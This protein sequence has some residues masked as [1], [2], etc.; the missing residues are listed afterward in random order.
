ML[1]K[2]IAC[3]CSF[4]LLFSMTAASYAEPDDGVGQTIQIYTRF[5]T[6]VGRPSWLLVIRDVDHNQNIPYLFDIERG[7][8][9]WLAFTRGRNYLITIS[10][11]QFAP[12]KGMPYY[13]T[14]KINNFCHLESNGRIIR[15][16]SLYITIKGNLTP[17]TNT[18]TCYVSRYADSNFTIA[19]PKAAE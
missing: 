19:S 5:H 1:K 17:N 4:F 12:Y 18:F 7:T 13:N 16:E 2:Y 3:L 14:R 11:L 9:F 6:F 10:N 8:N 15:G